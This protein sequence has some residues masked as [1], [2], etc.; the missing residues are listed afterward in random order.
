M[1]DRENYIA[2]YCLYRKLF[3]KQHLKALNDFNKTT[4]G[5]PTLSCFIKI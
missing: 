3:E 4:K 2:K 5:F 1:N